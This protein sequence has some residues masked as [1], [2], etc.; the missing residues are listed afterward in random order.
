MLRVVI[1]AGGG[2]AG[3]L[4]RYF[5]QG[6]ILDRTGPSV[7]ALFVVNISGSFAIGLISTLAQERGAI[8]P[9]MRLLLT[10]GFLSAYTTFSS[11]M[12]ES[13]QL[14]EAGEIA[15]ATANVL[16]SVAV[17]VVAVWLGILLARAM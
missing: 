5:L 10:T 13:V 1:V 6:W 16:G 17:G 3:A 7:I 8:S 11:W 14:I 12:Y 15:R 9:E 2:I 4:C